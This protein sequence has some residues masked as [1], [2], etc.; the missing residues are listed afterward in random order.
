MHISS[1]LP[2]LLRFLAVPFFVLTGV[3]MTYPEKLAAIIRGTRFPRT[4]IRTLGA[5]LLLVHAN[6]K[7]MNQWGMP[8]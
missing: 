4:A 7:K 6:A 5:D 2:F 3:A 1:S 8:I